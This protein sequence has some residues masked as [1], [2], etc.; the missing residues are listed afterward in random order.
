LVIFAFLAQLWDD[1][2]KQKLTLAAENLLHGLFTMNLEMMERIALL[3]RLTDIY[4][5]RKA[6]DNILFI[7]D[8]L[9]VADQFNEDGEL[10]EACTELEKL[11]KSP[12]ILDCYFAEK[13]LTVFFENFRFL[14]NYKI[15]SMKKIE[16]FNIKNIN[17]GYL[18]HYVN[19]GYKSKEEEKRNF[20]NCHETIN[21]LFTNAVLLYKGTDYTTNINLFPF[22]IDY[23]ALT[24]EKNS[25]IAFFL[26]EGFNENEIEYAFLDTDETFELEYKGIVQQKGGTNVVFLTDE[27]MKVYNIDCVFDTFRIIQK[28]LFMTI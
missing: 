6:S 13:Y 11:G 18:H 28:K 7:A 10:Y 15:A 26:Q 12:T 24:L 20:D 2:H 9:K 25:K 27:D 14:V 23:N 1:V 8:I 19:A 22:V 16:Y 21:S 17:V 5:E 4:R 3:Q